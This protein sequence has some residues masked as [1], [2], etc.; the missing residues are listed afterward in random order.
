MNFDALEN[1]P[2]L[3][4]EADLAPLQGTRFQ[5]TGFPDLGAAEYEASGVRMLLVES[6]QSMA[7]RL[8]A[9]CWDEARNDWVHEL[10]GLPYV[11]STLPDGSTTSSVLEA[12]RINSPFICSSDGFSA[13]RTAIGFENNKPFDRRALAAAL[14]KFDPNSLIHGVFLEKVG[15]V[16]RLPRML[17]ASIEATDVAIAAS[18]GVKVD[19]VQPST[20]GDNTPYGKANEGYGN[21]PFHRDEYVAKKITAFFNLDLALLRG[22]GLPAEA[23]QLLIAWSLYKIRRLLAEGLRLRT[24]CDLEEREL[25]TV[26]PENFTLPSLQEL[27]G[28]LPSLVKA[29]ATNFNEPRVLEVKYHKKAK[30]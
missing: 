29:A 17:S 2:R 1:Q 11:R 24:A 5:P 22:Y 6:A 8:E 18:G 26:R 19:R 23:Q 21:V 12:H 10:K 25:R 13:I 7:N 15:G 4:V 27:S 9:V 3:L 16:V 14:L 20:T 30:A 28:A